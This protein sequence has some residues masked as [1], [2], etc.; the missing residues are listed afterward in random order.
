MM[1][2]G[3]LQAAN[4]EL[5][6]AVLGTGSRGTEMIRRSLVFPNVRIAAVCDVREE[7][8]TAAQ[9]IVE[10]A[11]QP[12]PAPFTRGPEDYRRMLESKDIDAVLIMTPQDQH[13]AQAIFAMEHGKHVGSETPAIYTID[14]AWALVETKEKTGRRYGFLENYP[15]ARSR[16]M[17][18]NMAHTGVLG[19][20]TYGES[21]YIHDTRNLAYEKDGTLSWR[22]VIASKHRG[23]I[24]PTHGLGPVSLWM[25]VNRGDRY[26]SMVTMDSG[27]KGLQSFAREQFGPA[28]AAAQPGF[29]AK[30]DTTITL[31][32]TAGERMVVLRY[33]S[34]SARPAG[35][36]ESLQGTKGAYDGSPGY[37]SIYL[38]GRGPK[39]KWEPLANY[40]AQFE[41]PYWRADGRL[42]AS[43]GH[44]GGDYFVLREF[45]SALAEDREPPI[46]V[47]DGVTWSAVLPLSGASIRAGSQPVQMPDFTRGKWRE[48]TLTGFGIAGPNQ[49]KADEIKPVG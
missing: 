42:A 23:D 20:T 16:M 12:A 28:H 13:A 10:A 21:S 47:Y 9:R 18:L 24:Y 25:G 32:K 33:D 31:L 3:G 22:G 49:R 36:W 44:G 15:Y 8:A 7:R 4:R 14:Q 17:I 27:T 41:H 35:G 48:R 26:V 19:E 34:G 45:Y 39:E 37:E 38:E 2:A 40:R 5:R 29:F 6:V 43:A 46:D 1:A 11:G 30:R